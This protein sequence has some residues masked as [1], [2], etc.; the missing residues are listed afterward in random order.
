MKSLADDEVRTR[1]CKL[2]SSHCCYDW[3]SISGFFRF[4]KQKKFDIGFLRET[5][6]LIAGLLLGFAGCGLQS[7]C[8]VPEHNSLSRV[9]VELGCESLL[10]WVVVGK[11]KVLKSKKDLVAGAARDSTA[12]VRVC[13]STCGC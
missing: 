7:L 4:G 5:A 8:L 10:P 6:C 9:S 13:V 1:V 2:S 3:L 11:K 12:W